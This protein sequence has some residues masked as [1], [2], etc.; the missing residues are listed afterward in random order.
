MTFGDWLREERAY[1][2]LTYRE[3]GLLCAVDWSMLYR[4]EHLQS[5]PMLSTVLRICNGLGY[6]PAEVFL[7]LEPA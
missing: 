7:Q 4:I 3:L 2:G 1:R 6:T 5:D